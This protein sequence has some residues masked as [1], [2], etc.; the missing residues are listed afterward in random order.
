M[1]ML[2]IGVLALQGDFEAHEKILSDLGAEVVEVRTCVHLSQVSG[3]ILPG[4]ESTTISILMEREGLDSAI[5]RRAIEG[6]PVYGTCAG[7]ILMAA[8]I[9]DRPDQP[10]LKL[11]DITVARNAFGRQIDSFEADIEC[12]LEDTISSENVRGVFIRAPYVVEMSSTVTEIARY[13][14]RIVGVK[15]GSLVGTAFHPE[16]IMETRFHRYFLQLA[17]N[18][19]REP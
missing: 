9:Q 5:Q 6:M 2:K 8:T 13:E 3:L 11:L 17:E 16:L 12:R 4:G 7:L 14:G 1:S 18:Y 19:I 10:S 15:Q